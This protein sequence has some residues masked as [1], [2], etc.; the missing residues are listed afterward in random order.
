MSVDQNS[1]GATGKDPSV[2]PHVLAL[3]A[4]V[5][6]LQVQPDE[7]LSGED[8]RQR[9][10]K[11]GPNQLPEAPP[12]SAWRVFLAQFKSILIMILIGAATLA[13]LIGNTKDALVILAVVLINATVGF[14]QEYRAEQ[15]LAALKA[16]LPVRA[17]VRRESKKIEVAAED[18]VPGDVVLLEAG[19][20]VPADGRLLLSAGLEVDE[21]A[22]TGESQPVGKQLDALQATDLPLAE[23][24]NM[25]YMNTLLTRGRAEIIVT[26]TGAQ[27]E[28]GQLSQ[29]LA[30]TPEVPTPLQLQLDQLGKRLGAIALTLVGLLSALA[31]WRGDTLAHIA[32]DAIALAVAAM[33]EGL[34]VVVTVTLALGMRNM[35]RHQA[36][37]KRLASVETLGCT[38]V[39]CSDKTGT[40]T[41]NQMTARAFFY[42]EQRFNVSGEGYATDGEISATGSAGSA[43]RLP[44]LQ[45]LL[46]PLVACNDS[47]VDHGKVIGDPME[48]ALLVLAHKGGLDPGTATE[49]L[50]RLA[51][52]P[53]DAAHKFMATF[54]QEDGQVRMFVKGAPDV[55]LA[56]C[57]Q[58]LNA[59]TEGPL[60]GAARQ[61]I[62]AHYTELGSQGLRGLLV[63][64]R[65][66]ANSAFDA[67]GDLSA[68]VSDLSFVGLIG[69]M[70]PPRAEAKVAIAE[71]RAAG[72]TVK[73]IT[74][75]HQLT[76]SA[77]AA[78]LGLKG[79]AMTGAELER[80]NAEQ[81]A[82]AIDDVAVFAR[83]TPSNKVKIVRVLQKKGAVVAMTGDGV[84][85][86]PALKSADIGVAMG[87]GTAVAKAAATM[88]LLDDNFATLVSAVRQG[89]TLYDNI[90]KFVRFQLSTTIGAILCVFFAPLLGLPEPFTAVQI[91]WVAIIMDGPPAVSLAMDAAR[92]GLMH[93]PPRSRSK[94]LLTLRRLGK[95]IA[96]GVTMMMGTLAVLHFGLQAGMAQQAPTLAFTT[97]V[98][99]QFF[100][101]FNARVERGTAF[102]RHFF[103][104]T[105]LWASLAGVI[106]LQVIAVHWPPAQSIFG[107]QSLSL[108][109]WGIATGTAA[110][111]LL[112]EEGR[113]LAVALFERLRSG[114]KA[115]EPLAPKEAAQ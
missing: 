76:A 15:S 33:P 52:I 96:Y 100:N 30:A 93:E 48:A 36:I 18:L 7:G 60:D 11:Y 9:K 13:A 51:E 56:L 90:V 10:E 114:P 81:L 19:D 92:P 102:N 53:F 86:A 24:S 25:L 3:D 73:M 2:A 103:K 94:P 32:L 113:K 1:D 27:S 23:R 61:Q 46:L 43:S 98:L 63:A 70:D 47:R 109:Q 45:A 66:I 28:M 58:A 79:T 75:D 105:M 107:T 37:V 34:P 49:A 22:L 4:L 82:A 44:D 12:R 20:P 55:L 88:V 40:L 41:L 69:L 104:N 78:E 67:A 91:L 85:D 8:I 62:E 6:Q 26:A 14:Y 42:R 106:G 77:I 39:I 99:F 5:A 31:L 68:W 97:F 17:R 29:E 64:S 80:L 112:L 83:V 59:S 74:G 101:V 87:S 54:H 38:T 16:M 71:C 111:I 108:G 115:P 57:T 72:I 65:S 95:I 110:T 35:A 21:S 84:N 50:P 89:R